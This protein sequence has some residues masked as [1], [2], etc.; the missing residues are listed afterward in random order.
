MMAQVRV[1]AAAASVEVL[2]QTVQR[3]AGRL[4]AA[5]SQNTI[6]IPKVRTVSSRCRMW[7]GAGVCV[8]T[9]RWQRGQ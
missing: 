3:W 2:P 7:L 9:W 6:Q 5:Q 4:M 1:L 8:A